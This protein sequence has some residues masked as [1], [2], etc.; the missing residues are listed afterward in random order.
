MSGSAFNFTKADIEA[1]RPSPDGKRL[2]FRDT[3]TTGLEL[4]VTAN[5][6]KTFSL[7]RRVRGGDVERHTIGRFPDVSVTEAR[8]KANEFIPKLAQGTSIAQQKRDKKVEQTFGDLFD[9]YVKR[10]AKPTKR[11]WK[12]DETKYR[13]HLAQPLGGKKLSKIAR[14]DIAAVHSKLTLSGQPTT[15]NRVLA[16]VSSVY[17]WAKSAGLWED[18]PAQASSATQSSSRIASCCKFRTNCLVP[19]PPRPP[20]PTI[21]DY[22]LSSTAHWRPARQRALDA[23]EGR[24]YRTCGVAHP[25]D[26]ER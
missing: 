5:G 17:G 19:R 11:T 12:E 6:V 21:R 2:V 20:T 9:D 15:A 18:N 7:R 26:Q 4:R 24:L 13:M 10:H 1:I 23:L 25:A 3:K 14:R 22:L 8:D 16:L